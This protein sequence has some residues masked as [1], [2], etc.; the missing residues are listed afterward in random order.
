MDRFTVSLEPELFTLL[1]DR[2][3]YNRRSMSQEMVFL[4]ECALA[5]E[6]DGNLS[7]LRTLMMAGGG[8]KSVPALGDQSL[9]HTATDESLLDS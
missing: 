3:A 6:I 1:R 2:A 7:I 4:I 8:V 9:E 5:S